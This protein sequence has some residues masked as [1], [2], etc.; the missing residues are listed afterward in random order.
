MS[1][2]LTRDCSGALTVGRACRTPPQSPRALDE[3]DF[4]EP[5]S[6]ATDQLEAPNAYGQTPLLV[7]AGN[8]S[9]RVATL[10]LKHGADVNAKD[11][12]GKTAL[13]LA[14][15]N[16]NENMV[17][18]LLEDSE[19]TAGTGQGNG[20]PVLPQAEVTMAEQENEEVESEG[21]DP[22]VVALAKA[23]AAV[24][25]ADA[26]EAAETAASAAPTDRSRAVVFGIATLGKA[27]R[28][29]ADGSRA[30]GSL[31]K[32]A[33]IEPTSAAADVSKKAPIS[34]DFGAVMQ[35]SAYADA[36][37]KKREKL[38]KELQAAPPSL[39]VVSSGSRK[40]KSPDDRAAQ[41]D[42]IV[43]VCTTRYDLTCWQP[44]KC[45]RFG[46]P[47]VCSV[48]SSACLLADSLSD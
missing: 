41:A 43:Q 31:T 45:D 33:H 12:N 20:V 32:G 46:S 6:K 40:A 44:L 2:A 11:A 9:S 34:G 38:D 42:Q 28:V 4:D 37:R 7:A 26:D 1:R 3:E 10:L 39:S 47:S 14:R 25:K 5:T 18:L 15:V 23:A 21:E 30:A 17:S 24:A 27:G 35:V 19:R 16:N 29:R 48:C 36:V 13:D 22:I 8:G